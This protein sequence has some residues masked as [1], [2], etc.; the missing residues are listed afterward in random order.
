MGNPESLLISIVVPIFNTELFLNECIDS[1][2]AQ[3][4]RN[5]E[6]L[7]IDDGSTDR[8]KDICDDYA[9]LDHRIRVVHKQNEGNISA[10]KLGVSLSSGDYIGFVDSDDW[11]LPNMYEVLLDN[12][13]HGEIDIVTSDYFKYD[14]G[15]AVIIE[16][17]IPKGVYKSHEEMQYI[18]SNM[19][20]WNHTNAQG[21]TYSLC[22]KL[23]R[24]SILDNVIQTISKDS[25]FGEDAAV[26]FMTLMKC[27]SVAIIREAFYYYRMNENSIVHGTNEDYLIGI[28]K[29]YTLL[30]REFSNNEDCEI[31]QKQLEVYVVSQILRGIN[32][33]IGF[34]DNVM[35]PLYRF[36]THML[37]I[38]SKIVLY[39]AGK[40]GKSFYTQFMKEKCFEIVAWVDQ[41]AQVYQ[42]RGLS[43]VGV[44]TIQTLV[45][46]YIIIA[47][48]HENVSKLVEKEIMDQGIEPNKVMWYEPI[49]LISL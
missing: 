30:K 2:L 45:F 15:K 40:V 41:K 35:I 25:T 18:L 44:E 36:P 42:E 22:N 32:Y 9:R 5:I 38:H 6:V 48:L 12:A 1:I 3:T 21:I 20:F 47:V 10:R 13:N 34:S 11:I 8:S 46:D 37:P 49:C 4:Y 26:T 43:V 14:N 7:L 27:K 16:N 29:I 17:K 31:L 33:Y 23:F 39:G 19:I 24:K 28:N